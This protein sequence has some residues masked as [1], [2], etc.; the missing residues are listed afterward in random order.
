MRLRR[1]AGPRSPSPKRAGALGSIGF[2][3]ALLIAPL[4]SAHAADSLA[5]LW[6]DAWRAG[7]AGPE[8]LWDPTA[9]WGSIPGVSAEDAAVIFG[10]VALRRM[11][12]ET[13]SIGLPDRAIAR[14]RAFLDSS[15]PPVL[16][17]MA[18]HLLGIFSHV[19]GDP[20][21]ANEEWDRLGF[22]SDF[23]IIGPFE[24]ERGSGFTANYE[25]ERTVDLS[26]ELPGKRGNIRWRRWSERGIAGQ[27]DTQGT[28]TSSPARAPT[29]SSARWRAAK[30]EATAA[31]PG[32]PCI[33][34]NSVSK[35][36]TLSPMASS[37]RSKARSRAACSA[38]PR[39]GPPFAIFMRRAYVS[40]NL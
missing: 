20:A 17:G 25:P 37:P 15:P 2:L 33:A 3:V 9:T 7:H 29:P 38:S 36:S 22:L 10:E 21:A 13:L 27:V 6:D 28:R 30:P 34:A 8:Q 35:S 1:R 16:E 18:R 23:Q 14:L 40:T 39:H 24:N 26:A 19:A 4:P 5:P 11:H 12:E 32:R 31:A